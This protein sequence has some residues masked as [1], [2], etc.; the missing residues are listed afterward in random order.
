MIYDGISLQNR[1][2]SNM[3]CVLLKE[4]VIAGKPVFLGVVC[5][6]VGSMADGAFASSTAV[7]LLS[8]WMDS[9]ETTKRIGLLLLEYVN[10]INQ[11]IV[12]AAA[13]RH[14]QTASTLSALL[15]CE[16]NYYVV[17]VGDS[18]IYSYKNSVLT[19]LTHDQSSNGKLTSCLGRYER[20]TILYNE[21]LYTGEKFLL[22]SDGLYKRMSNAEIATEMSK[23]HAK[24]LYKSIEKM[25]QRVVEQGEKDNVSLAILLN[26]EWRNIQ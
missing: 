6:G 5:D 12:F 9:L 20:T 11:R 4:R 10:E 17:H 19:Q 15:L 1:R 25:A 26:D 3:D 24:N 8:D 21:G 2:K 22:C 23:I 18:R 14:L 7:R 13:E 16:D